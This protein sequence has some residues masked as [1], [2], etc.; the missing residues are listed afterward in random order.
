MLIHDLTY[1]QTRDMESKY[2]NEWSIIFAR[3]CILI[4]TFT[5]AWRA[6]RQFK[7]SYEMFKKDTQF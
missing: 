2:R 4:E 1:Y 6:D 3:A 5:S 7:E